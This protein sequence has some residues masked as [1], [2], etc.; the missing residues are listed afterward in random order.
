M[1]IFKIIEEKENE[2]TI[3][4]NGNNNIILGNNLIIDGNEIV[5]FE[6]YLDQSMDIEK[7]TDSNINNLE[8]RKHSFND[9]FTNLRE[10]AEYISPLLSNLKEG[11]Y[12]LTDTT[13]VP[14]N[15]E[16]NFFADY[17]KNI[18]GIDDDHY[19][20]KLFNIQGIQ[21]KDNYNQE[22]ID[23]YIKRYK[24]SNRRPRSIVAKLKHNDIE[25]IVLDGHHKICA[26][27]ALGELVPA[28]LIEA[29]DKIEKD[30]HTKTTE[31]EKF[32][33]LTNNYKD[34][35]N[36]YL[37]FNE[38]STFITNY[39]YNTSSETYKMMENLLNN[40]FNKILNEDEAIKL[41]NTCG[42]GDIK[43]MLVKMLY[44]CKSDIVF[45]F[46]TN[47]LDDS[48]YSEIANNYIQNYMK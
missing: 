23:T 25:G 14:L 1:S 27:A 11:K 39:R 38:Y 17:D 32:N 33:I 46:F 19:S 36:K 4:V 34:I 3:Y 2:L 48:I 7:V 37:S 20:K 43:I 31:R 47:L 28:I 5:W 29:L 6:E 12:K 22:T 30:N 21:N 44:S 9:D 45:D 18:F 41:F 15:R 24:N 10:Y 40:Y 13:V 35:K 16:G 8:Y 42:D 26:S